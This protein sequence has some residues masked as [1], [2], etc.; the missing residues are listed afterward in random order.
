VLKFALRRKWIT[1][2]PA[3]ELDAPTVKQKPTLPFSDDEMKEILKAAKTAKDPRAYAFILAMR[4]SGLRISDTALLAVKNLA[5]N[6]LRLHQAKTGE[7]VTG[8]LPDDVAETLKAAPRT[9]PKYFFWTGNSKVTHAAEYWRTR[10]FKIFKKANI[11][12]GHSHRFRDTYAVDLLQAGV[13]LE[14][15]S[16]LLGHRSIRITERHYSPWVKTRQDA[17]DRELLRVNADRP[18]EQNGNN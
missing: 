1:E 8:I 6:R 10:L 18:R 14:N 13:S 4:Y 16:T 5:G 9:N 12:N 3:I 11:V 15:V 2:N 7:A 17:L